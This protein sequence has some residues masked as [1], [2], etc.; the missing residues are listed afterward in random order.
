MSTTD[1]L[2]RGIEVIDMGTP[3]NVPFGWE[4]AACFAAP[5]LLDSSTVPLPPTGW[6]IGERG[7]TV[8]GCDKGK[9]PMR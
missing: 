3:L 9:I 1:G 7:R 5:L 8:K 4:G 2:M 6:A